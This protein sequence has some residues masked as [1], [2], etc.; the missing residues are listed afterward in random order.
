MWTNTHKQDPKASVPKEASKQEPYVAVPPLE[1]ASH[2]NG[3]VFSCFFVLLYFLL[4]VLHGYSF[5]LCAACTGRR[6]LLANWM[7]KPPRSRTLM[8]T[9][10]QHVF[11]LSGMVTFLAVALNPSTSQGGLAVAVTVSQLFCRR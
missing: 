7:P 4:F 9:C 10:E 5:F 11:V 3:F 1:K 2:M 6:P 8:N